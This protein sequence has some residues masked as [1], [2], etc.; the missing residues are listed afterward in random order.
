MSCQG[1]KYGKGAY[2]MI[3]IDIYRRGVLVFFGPKDDFLRFVKSKD[4]G[5]SD[6]VAQRVNDDD[7]STLA[8]CITTSTDA[9]IYAEESPG[10]A[11]IVHESAHAAMGI[12][13]IVGISPSEEEAFAYLQEYICQHIF[14]W[15][16]LS[17][18]AQSP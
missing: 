13:K 3:P 18:D 6:L 7:G 11:C 17:C 1:K 12:L 4:A 9:Y 5:N 14:D 15:L 10:I 8:Q 2:L 16:N